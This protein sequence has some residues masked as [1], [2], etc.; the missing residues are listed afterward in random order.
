MNAMHTND[1]NVNESSG[2]DNS[3]IATMIVTVAT[4]SICMVI[5]E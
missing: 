4:I 1:T 2:G 5:I 3:N